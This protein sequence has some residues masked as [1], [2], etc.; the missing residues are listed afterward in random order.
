MTILS[1]DLQNRGRGQDWGQNWG[2]FWLEH[3]N[4]YFY[5]KFQDPNL[6]NDWARTMFLTSKIEVEVKDEVKIEVSSG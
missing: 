3:L 4:I 5:V 1:F 6:K 2:Q